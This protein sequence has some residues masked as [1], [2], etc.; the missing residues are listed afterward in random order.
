MN[1]GIKEEMIKKMKNQKIVNGSPLVPYPWQDD[2]EWYPKWNKYGEVFEKIYKGVGSAKDCILAYA[3]FIDFTDTLLAEGKR[4]GVE[5]IQKELPKELGFDDYGKHVH[6]YA[7]E[8]SGKC[9]ICG[10]SWRTT[11]I[12]EYYNNAIIQVKKLLRK[13]LKSQSEKGECEKKTELNQ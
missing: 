4:Q 3:E 9:G 7:T 13:K 1:S 10:L 8:G 12:Y 5:E 6:T 2:G 11:T